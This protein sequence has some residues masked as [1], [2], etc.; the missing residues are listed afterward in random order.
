MNS[1]EMNDE[2]LRLAIAR[3]I[4]KQNGW[5]FRISGP[6]GD[7]PHWLIPQEKA[8]HYDVK[9]IPAWPCDDSAALDLFNK[10]DEVDIWQDST[11]WNCS[12]GGA[13]CHG[14]PFARALSECWLN[15][16]E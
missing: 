7:G 3:V 13:F 10:N 16:R 2:Q 6:V 12:F 14:K 9:Y 4:A 1:S 5:D 15:S 11:G 8:G